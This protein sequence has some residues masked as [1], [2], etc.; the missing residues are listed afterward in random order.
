[1]TN[2]SVKNY[3]WDE[4]VPESCNYITP[5]LIQEV[6]KIS[7]AGARILDIGSGNGLLCNDLKTEGYNTVGVELD[8]K[9]VELSRQS[10]PNIPFYNF[11]VEETPDRLLEAEKIFNVVVSTEVIEHLYAPHLLPIYASKCLVEGGHLVISTPYH[12]YFKNLAL[13]VF[14]K[15]D[16]HHTPL[17]H[18]GHV[19]FWSK[20]TITTLLE[21]NGFEVVGFR[22]AGRFPYMW[23]SM[24]IIARK[25]GS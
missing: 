16:F 8:Q 2:A 12:G 21:K 1:M 10:F 14:N 5:N 13:S 17:W 22:G 18:G 11:S 24:I 9:G 3:G 4:D 7:N 15:W 6:R 19:K 25:I 20:A 23:K